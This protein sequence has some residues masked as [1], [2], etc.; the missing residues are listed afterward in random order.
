MKIEFFSSA[1]ILSMMR[2]KRKKWEWGKIREKKS[3]IFNRQEIGADLYAC[4]ELVGGKWISVVDEIKI[5]RTRALCN[6]IILWY[7][8]AL[9]HSE[10]SNDSNGK[11]QW[12][13]GRKFFRI[14][15]AKNFST[16]LRGEKCKSI[17]N[18]RFQFWERINF[19]P[20]DNNYLI[21][22]GTLF[23]STHP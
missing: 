3:S 6:R 8:W 16:S 12:E 15:Y 21:Q 2:T 7:L 4:M 9:T 5:I 13:E 22:Y 11:R 17:F 10:N 23:N 18:N 19:L 14:K 1:L 20:V